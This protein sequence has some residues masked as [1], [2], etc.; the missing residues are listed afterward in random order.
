MHEIQLG[1]E[2]SES[3]HE[4]AAARFD[5]RHPQVYKLVE[6]FALEAAAREGCNRIGIGAIWER[7]RWYIHVESDTRENFKL[8]NSYRAYYARR[9]LRDHPEHQGLFETRRLRSRTWIP[10]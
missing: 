1:F 2:A 8:N 7:I 4:Q 5:E 10:A 3:I 6:R 9:F